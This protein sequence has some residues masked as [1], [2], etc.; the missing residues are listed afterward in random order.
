LSIG[1]LHK[2]AKGAW[3]EQI[4]IKYLIEKGYDVFRAV[5]YTGPVDI[6]AMKGKKILLIDVK[7]ASLRENKNSPKYNMVIRRI[8]SKK[9]IELGVYLMYI[10]ADEKVEFIP[11]LG[12]A[13]KTTK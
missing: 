6:I 10:G 2:H 7:L 9:Q 11:E 13:K 5:K 3:A 4:A 8:R 12:H 1:K